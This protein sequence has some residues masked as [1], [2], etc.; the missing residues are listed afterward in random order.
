MAIAAEHVTHEY[1]SG[2][3]LQVKALQD[4]SMRIEEGEIVGLMG[5]TGCGKST[6]MQILAGLITPVSGQ[7]LV[8]GEDIF[9]DDYRREKL[10]R[11][12]GVVFQYPENQL[13]ESTVYKDVSF[14]L[15][16]SGLSKEEKEANV[17]WALQMMGFHPEAVGPLSP[18]GLSGG[19]KRRIAIAG[20]LAVKP[21]YLI[22][23]EPI[24]GLDPAGR[25]RFV[26]LLRELKGDGMSILM[27][28]H[29]ADAIAQ[30]A[31]RLYLMKKGIIYGGGSTGE[32]FADTELI[33]SCGVE[34]SGPQRIARALR[35]KGVELPTQRLA[36][37]GDAM[38]D[39]PAQQGQGLHR[40]PLTHEELMEQLVSWL[41][42]GAS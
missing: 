14:G 4:V 38:G 31:D 16:H 27:I 15:K 37:P 13:F 42:G 9:A 41:N 20:V 3:A 17:K 6:L 19:E 28:S 26:Q 39:A 32:V 36:Q 25:E 33:H 8:D 29:N 5:H 12:L 18:L 34:V 30:C 40:E 2:T 24:A 35:E 1:E 11:S 22:L 23:D 21:K 7:V 10:R